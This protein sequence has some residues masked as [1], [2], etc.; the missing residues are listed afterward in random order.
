MKRCALRVAICLLA[1]LFILVL[2][3]CSR[4]E[5]TGPKASNTSASTNI[6][7]SGPSK[8]SAEG[9]ST[10]TD[11]S[12]DDEQDQNEDADAEAIGQTGDDSEGSAEDTEAQGQNAGSSSGG[13]SRNS[14]S[15]SNG[16]GS[17]TASSGGQGTGAGTNSSGGNVSTQ[18]SN[19][20]TGQSSGGSSNQNANRNSGQGSAG[21]SSQGNTGTGQSQSGGSNQSNT[22]RTITVSIE[23]E[24]RLAHAQNPAALSGIANNGIILARRNVTLQEGATVRQALDATGIRVNARG[25]YI[26]GIGGLSEGDIGP[27]SGWMFS[28]NGQFPGSSA[29]AQRL[30]AGDVIAW[31]Y[32]LNGGADLGASW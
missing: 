22:P 17:S 13:S 9:T 24:A 27:R 1:A 5:H 25:A 4:P 14:N 31:R 20:N 26:A 28:V 10:A 8:S 18:N 29:S 32:T 23:I 12:L 21:N 6:V 3:G 30:N 2:A 15:G 19:R 16:S 7:T 11:T